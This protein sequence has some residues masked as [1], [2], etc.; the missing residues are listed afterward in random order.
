MKKMLIF[1]SVI[2]FNVTL[3]NESQP[4][5]QVFDKGMFTTIKYNIIYSYL[6]SQHMHN[7]YPEFKEIRVFELLEDENYEDYGSLQTL[8]ENFF[9]KSEKLSRSNKPKLQK[10]K[11]PKN[12]NT[13]EN[14]DAIKDKKRKIRKMLQDFIGS[15]DAIYC[16]HIFP[17]FNRDKEEKMAGVIVLGSL[18]PKHCSILKEKFEKMKQ[19]S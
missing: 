1:L 3:A 19:N 10:L 2:I 6:H 5:Y 4:T 9:E 11:K 15:N 17:Y 13:V 12:N 18:N 7:P 8:Q 16:E 14:K